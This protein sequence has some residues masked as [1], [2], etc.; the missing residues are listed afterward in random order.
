MVA[1][2]TTTYQNNGLSASTPYFYRVRATNAVGNSA[3][4]AVATA[5]TGAATGG[6]TGGVAIVVDGNGADWSTVTPLTTSGAGGVTGLKVYGDA[7]YLYVL[8]TG[9]TNTNYSVFIDSDNATATGFK[10]GLWNPEGSDYVLENG[11]LHKYSGSGQ[12]WSWS[13]V[14]VSQGGIL[15]VKTAG[16]LEIR[17]PRASLAGSGASLRLGVDIENAS[18]TTVGTIPASGSAQATF[19]F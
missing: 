4:T 6:G 14:G 11:V 19:A 17:I 15:A 7:S 16:V 8:A 2:N 3:Y 10:A 5:A 18:W 1:A 9:A 12:N 13:T